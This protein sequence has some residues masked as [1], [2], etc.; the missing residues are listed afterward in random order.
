[1]AFCGLAQDAV[2]ALVTVVVVDG[3]EVVEVARDQRHRVAGNRR[4][5]L[6]LGEARHERIA[7]QQ[8][9]ERIDDRLLAELD[10]GRR[11]G[12]HGRDDVHQQR[13][14]REQQDRVVDR[15]DRMDTERDRDHQE[16]G[17]TR[18]YQHHLRAEA[19]RRQ[20]A[21]DRDP[22]Q[23]RARRSASRR[24][25]AGDD[26]RG[27]GE[28]LGDHTLGPRRAADA[29]VERLQVHGAQGEEREDVPAQERGRPEH[30]QSDRCRA[31]LSRAADART[32]VERAAPVGIGRAQPGGL[33]TGLHSCLGLRRAGLDLE[34][35]RERL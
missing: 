32:H 2:T 27:P 35:H 29:P 6:E 24:H 18:T 14:R 10:L 8:A 12:G 33:G 17:R 20:R 16:R 9:G 7:V 30:R 26:E 25:G 22:R 13:E 23:Q 3:L 15:A 28:A 34:V 21:G 31:E 1:M 11:H 19:R 5:G 4:L